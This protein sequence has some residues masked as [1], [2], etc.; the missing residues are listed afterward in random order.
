MSFSKCLQASNG[1]RWKFYQDKDLLYFIIQ[2]V[3]K[4]TYIGSISFPLTLKPIKFNQYKKHTNLSQSEK[5][6]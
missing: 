6:T 1:N 4:G 2:K 3:Q 5:E